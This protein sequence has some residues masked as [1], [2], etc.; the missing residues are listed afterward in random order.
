MFGGRNIL[1]LLLAICLLAVSLLPGWAEETK[2]AS[3]PEAYEKIAE[4]SRFNL[5]LR[6]DTLALIVESKATGKV[7]YSTV[8]NPEDMKDNAAWKGFYQSGIVM[9]Y[10]EGV[11]NIP[12]QADFI[13][14]PNEID[15]ALTG[16]GYVARVTYPDLSISYEVT[17]K[18]D[19][20]GFS[21]S[22]PYDKIVE[23]NADTYTVASFY[24]YPFMGYSYL[25]DRVERQRGAL[26]LSL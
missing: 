1:A 21:V 11:K 10:L 13:N 20:L 19:E 16:D 4:N 14:T 7:M 6:R 24:V 15:C 25:G 17:L 3:L 12:L 22:I 26:F 8:Q 9:E 23:E 2:S 18:M 5:Y